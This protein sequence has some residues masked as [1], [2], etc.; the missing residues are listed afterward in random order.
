M[1]KEEK[2]LSEVG[3]RLTKA[4]FSVLPVDDGC[5][6]MLCD[7]EP[8][9]RVSEK[10]TVFYSQVD[11]EDPEK[12]RQI[13]EVV[14]QASVVKEYVRAFDAAQPLNLPHFEG[15]YRLLADFNGTC[16]AARESECGMQFV[17][18]DWDHDRNGVNAGHYF[19]NEYEPAKQDFAGRCGLIDWDE[20]FSHDQMKAIYRCISEY[21]EDG[22]DIGYDDARNLNEIRDKI[23]S[24]VPELGEE[25][26]EIHMDEMQ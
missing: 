16:L 26:H 7:C 11:G 22:A 25:K 8:L 1:T 17:T 2:Y 6:P 14:K 12:M 20:I 4:G 15:N 9:C 21:M 3:M 18:W 13:D 10:G 5:L 24:A 19:M 23:R